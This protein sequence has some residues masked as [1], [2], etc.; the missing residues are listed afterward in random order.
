MLRAD[1]NKALTEVGKGTP[2]GEFMRRYWIPAAKSEQV[3]KPG[4]APAR[5]RLLGEN[6]VV[7]RSPEGELGLIDE[8]CPHR[9]ASLVY[10]R[11]EP[12][13]VRCLYHGWK[14]ACDGR[15]LESPPEPPER[16]FA[17]KLSVTSYPVREAGGLI[18][19]Y[20]GPRELEPPFPKFPW[21]DLPPDQ[22][23][24]VKMHQAT[25]YLQGVEG[26]LDPAHPNYLHRDFDL[27]DKASWSGV[28][29]QSMAVIMSDGTPDIQCEE[30]PYLMR[31]A[32]IRKTADPGHQVCARVRVGR[33]VLLLHRDRSARSRG[34]SRPGTRSTTTVAT[35][36]TSTSTCT[37]RSTPRRSIR[38]GVIAPRR[39]TTRRR[40][41]SPTCTCRIAS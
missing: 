10:G 41:R 3:P 40:I 24:V 37:G 23:L 35:R 31:H 19:T 20:M 16:T 2:M 30:T 18:W 12:G 26:D 8:F 27:E 32:A 6:L 15:V 28:G 29:W 34:C 13:G 1:E 25:N 36:S 5:V 7:F 17:K 39:P 9:R 14:M 38:T 4:G 33:A 11:N 22:L 21:L